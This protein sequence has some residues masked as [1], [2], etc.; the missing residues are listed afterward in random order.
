MSLGW[1]FGVFGRC[2][3]GPGGCWRRVCVILEAC[4]GLMLA[5]WVFL[6]VL[7]VI[8]GGLGVPLDAFGSLL[9]P[10][11]SFWMA[12]GYLYRC[13]YGKTWHYEK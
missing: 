11:G 4:C 6:G 13:L 5:F 7:G 9:E 10:F 3:G 12:R 1:F 8:L 2:F